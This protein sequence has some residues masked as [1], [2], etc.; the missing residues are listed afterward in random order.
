MNPCPNGYFRNHASTWAPRVAKFF[1]LVAEDLQLDT[2]GDL[3]PYVNKHRNWLP[4]PNQEIDELDAAMMKLYEIQQGIFMKGTIYQHSPPRREAD[5]LHW[6]IIAGL[7]DKVSPETKEKLMRHESPASTCPPPQDPEWATLPSPPKEESSPPPPSPQPLLQMKFQPPL[8]P[9][10]PPKKPPLPQEPTPMSKMVDPP[11]LKMNITP[12]P[13]EVTRTAPPT[14]KMKNTLQDIPAAKSRILSSS[15]GAATRVSTWE[16]PPPIR[17]ADAHFHLQQLTQQLNMPLPQTLRMIPTP[18]Q[19]I[20]DPMVPS[21]CWPNTWHQMDHSLPLEA[22]RIALGWHPTLAREFGT[23]QFEEDFQRRAC[24][25]YVKAIGEVGL[26]YKR[27]KDLHQDQQQQQRQN[28]AALLKFSLQVAR[29][30]SL[31][32]VIHCRDAD[33]S[34]EASMDCMEVLRSHLEADHR[35]YL[36]CYSQGKDMLLRW[37]QLFHNL[38]LGISPIILSERPNSEMFSIVENLHADRLLLETD[39]PYLRPPASF[40]AQY[41]LERRTIPHPVTALPRGGGNPAIPGWGNRCR[42]PAGGPT[43]YTRFLPNVDLPP[44]HLQHCT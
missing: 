33:G 42:D 16:E 24:L 43:G 35:I 26:D 8:P 5:L 31:P 40:L 12:R 36:H 30:Q 6:R 39:A 29:K 13:Q 32:V 9:Q 14:R 41:G 23:G 22:S 2:I 34:C 11:K 38:K 28:Q 17:C 27:L 25:P 19:L 4:K 20:I 10:S 44:H 18:V 1:S 37:L 21:F 15:T 3:V 7:L